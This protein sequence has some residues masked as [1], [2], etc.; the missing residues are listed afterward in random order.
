ME[1]KAGSTFCFVVRLYRKTASHFSG[2]TLASARRHLESYPLSPGGD[3]G[4]APMWT[5]ESRSLYD[6]SKL[7]NKSELM[8]EE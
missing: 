7:R 2:R 8:D 3:T 5:N 1:S 6:R 4:G